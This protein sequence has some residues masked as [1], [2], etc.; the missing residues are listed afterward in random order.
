MI[1]PLAVLLSDSNYDSLAAL[2]VGSGSSGTI[3]SPCDC[4]EL[5]LCPLKTQNPESK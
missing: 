1:L 5:K 3:S 2:L 4:R